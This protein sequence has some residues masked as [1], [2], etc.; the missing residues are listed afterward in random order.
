[1]TP[2]ICEEPDYGSYETGHYSSNG[3]MQRVELYPEGVVES[4][5]GDPVFRT[6][7]RRATVGLMRKGTAMKASTHDY[8]LADAVYARINTALQERL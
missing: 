6:A 2:L 5:T 1:M 3:P 7:A 8:G 4:L